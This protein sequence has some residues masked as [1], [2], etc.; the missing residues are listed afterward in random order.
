VGGG[1]GG[2]A[3]AS[4]A[5]RPWGPVL[6]DRQGP[7]APTGPSMG[8]P[9]PHTVSHPG[10][11]I[12][13]AHAGERGNGGPRAGGRAGGA[14]GGAPWGRGWG[15]GC[16][17]AGEGATHPKKPRGEAGTGRAATR[18]Q[19]PQSAPRTARRG[20]NQV[21]VGVRRGD[22][23]DPAAVAQQPSL[24]EQ[25]VGEHGQGALAGVLGVRWNFSQFACVCVCVCGP[26]VV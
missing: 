16:P 12:L 18:R 21:G 23:G 5:V 11:A 2:G 20:H 15:G 17:C 24:G 25:S 4:L 1:R 7:K 13:L 8:S 9:Q 26:L 10:H 19:S 3:F 14:A 22:G 6:G